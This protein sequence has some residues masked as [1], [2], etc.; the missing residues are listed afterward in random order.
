MSEERKNLRDVLDELDRFFEEFERSL[1]QT[2]RSSVNTGQ[3]AFSKPVVAGMAMGFGPEGKPRIQFFG[4]NL[5]GP[6]GFR[7]PIY[8]QVVDEKEGNLRLL[9]EL[10]GVEKE[11]VQISA[12]EDRVSLNATKGERNYKMELTLQNAIDPESGTASYSNGILEVVFKLR[13]K[14]NKGY[15]RVRVV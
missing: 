5:V 6:D 7:A 13:D 3:K 4:D 9:V 1:E 14:T 8:E 12:L 2:I 15:R 10:P 11:D